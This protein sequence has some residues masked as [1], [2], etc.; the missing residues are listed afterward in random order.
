MRSPN[1]LLLK[2]L[3]RDST[4]H[5]SPVLVLQRREEAERAEKVKVLLAR[6]RSNKVAIHVMGDRL[7]HGTLEGCTLKL[8]RLRIKDALYALGLSD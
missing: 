1:E 3:E 8:D 5:I 7:A 4:A 2:Q 6:K